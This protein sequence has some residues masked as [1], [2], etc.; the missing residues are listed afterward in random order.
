[1]PVTNEYTDR[2][3]GY[4]DTVTI[5]EEEAAPAYPPPPRGALTGPLW[6]VVCCLGATAAALAILAVL[7]VLPAG[8]R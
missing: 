7:V 5:I 2:L 1:M 4:G 3:H 8:V 6:C